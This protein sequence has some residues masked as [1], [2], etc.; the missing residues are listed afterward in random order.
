MTKYY[1]SETKFF[2]FPRC[3]V[4]KWKIY[5]LTENFFRQINN[6]AISF[7]KLLLSHRFLP[8]KLESKFVYINTTLCCVTFTHFWQ[9]FRE[10]NFFTKEVTS[11]KKCGHRKCLVFPTLLTLRNFSKNL[12]SKIAEFVRDFT[13]IRNNGQRNNWS[14]FHSF[15]RYRSVV[16]VERSRSVTSAKRNNKLVSKRNTWR[17]DVLLLEGKIRNASRLKKNCK[18]F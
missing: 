3:G 2:I 16:S 7:V 17:K 5:S 11:R 10:S 9:N 6:L 1:F 18:P 4:V 15:Q 12:W 14:T 13:N 8:K